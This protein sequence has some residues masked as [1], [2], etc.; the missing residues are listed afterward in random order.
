[1]HTFFAGG[2]AALGIFAAFALIWYQVII[3]SNRDHD[4]LKRQD[5]LNHYTQLF[6]GRIAELQ[7][8][9]GTMAEARDTQDALSDPDPEA[10]ARL[11]T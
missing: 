7:S 9:V 4:A 11:G 10:K 3:E 8:Q 2:L 6:N 1:L 5:V